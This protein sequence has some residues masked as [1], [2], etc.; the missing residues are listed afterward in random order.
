MCVCARTRAHAKQTFHIRLGDAREALAPPEPW[1]T[2]SSLWVLD[3]KEDRRK[4][5]QPTPAIGGSG[6]SAPGASPLH[7]SSVSKE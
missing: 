7:A 3:T 6:L 4:F 5:P 1:I 2:L